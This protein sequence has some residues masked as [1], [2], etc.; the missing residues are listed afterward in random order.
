MRN[1]PICILEDTGIANG[2]RIKEALN[3]PRTE[4]AGGETYVF[5]WNKDFDPTGQL[6]QYE[7]KNLLKARDPWLSAAK[8]L[9]EMNGDIILFLDIQHLTSDGAPIELRSSD[10]SDGITNATMPLSAA[11]M[12]ANQML[13]WANPSRLG[14]LLAVHAAVN[15]NLS[16]VIIFSSQ[17]TDVGNGLNYLTTLSGNR[18]VWQELGYSL[19]GTTPERLANTINDAI[20]LFLAKREGAPIW[21]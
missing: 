10:F 21:S 3:F 12:D 9:S 17:R 11:G 16:G 20:Q 13:E 6:G 2:S 15:P 1:V 19:T 5:D 7:P 8:Y 18:V 14:L 4:V